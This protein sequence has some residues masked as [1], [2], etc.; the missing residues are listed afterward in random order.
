VIETIILSERAKQQLSTLKKRTKL[1]NWNV[2]CRWAF[3]LSLSEPSKPPHESVPSDSSVEMT[4]KT[5]TGRDD[6]T[7]WAL[8][9]ARAKRDGV[10]LSPNSLNLYFRLHLHR[11]ISFLTNRVSEDIASLV[12]LALPKGRAK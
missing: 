3:C 6:D 9:V 7:Y 4:W 12:E 10:D 8:L 5:F 1:K 2:I 11:G